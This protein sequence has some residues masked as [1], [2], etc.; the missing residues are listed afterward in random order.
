MNSPS[1]LFAIT[2]GIVDKKTD[3]GRKDALLDLKLRA[4]IRIALFCVRTPAAECQKTLRILIFCEILAAHVDA[5]RP[6]SIAKDRGS[7]AARGLGAG[8][9]VDERRSRLIPDTN[10][11]PRALAD[12]A[13]SAPKVP[14]SAL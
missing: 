8:R 5:A 4:V 1:K 9:I 6:Q 2:K 13:Q 3:A 11:C 14:E 7:C 12:A 10:F